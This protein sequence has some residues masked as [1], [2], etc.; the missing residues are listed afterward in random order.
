MESQPYHM[1]YTAVILTLCALKEPSAYERIVELIE[2][3]KV[4]L[5]FTG[6]LTHIRCDLGLGSEADFEEVERVRNSYSDM[7]AERG[8]MD[9]SPATFRATSARNP[10]EK[11]A[12]KAAKKK[13]KQQRASKKKNRKK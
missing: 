1:F 3:N 13:K 10:A 8:L 11:A 7:F 4:D 12:Q 2:A 9:F 5:N 6:N